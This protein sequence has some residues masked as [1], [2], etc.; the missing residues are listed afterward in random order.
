MNM[1]RG[2]VK[3]ST[4]QQTADELN[5]KKLAGK[6]LEIKKDIQSR[7]KYLKSYIGELYC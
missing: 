6:V 4:S 1:F 2:R 3:T 7:L 5:R